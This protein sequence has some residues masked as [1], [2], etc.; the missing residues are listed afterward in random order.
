[1]IW[2]VSSELWLF[3]CVLHLEVPAKIIT[4]CQALD[5]YIDIILLKCNMHV[6]IMNVLSNGYICLKVYLKPTF[7]LVQTSMQSL[8]DCVWKCTVCAVSVFKHQ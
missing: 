3:N 4:L 5:S 8:D 1:M 6:S 7:I 2:P